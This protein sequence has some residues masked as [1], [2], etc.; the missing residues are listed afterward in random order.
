[1]GL[2]ALAIAALGCGATKTQDYCPT[3]TATGGSVVG[4]WTTDGQP[5]C[6][7]PISR[8]SSGDWC[9]QLVFGPGGISNLQLGHPELA[10][11][12]GS[13]SFTDSSGDGKSGDYTS[14]LHYEGGETVWFPRE[15]IDAYGH[16]P[17]AKCA[18]DLTPALGAYLSDDGSAIQSYRALNLMQYN[19]QYPSYP[20][21]LA[22]KASYAPMDCTDDPRGG[23]DCPYVVAFDVPDK[24]Q[25]GVDG[26]GTLTLF[27]ATSAPPYP[28]DYGATATTLA[29]SGHQGFDLLGQPGLRM[30]QFAKK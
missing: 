25:W 22:P 26:A 2:G 3:V 21:G 15:C 29:I 10:F 19:A 13:L 8:V 5:F 27:S 14:L 30:I 17:P 20:P 7:A 24:G 6:V 4:E 11:K 23:C 16:V 1:V 9:S 18:D 28:N 12:T